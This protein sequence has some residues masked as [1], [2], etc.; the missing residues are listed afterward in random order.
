MSPDLRGPKNLHVVF[1]KDLKISLNCTLTDVYPHIWALVEYKKYK[2][3]TLLWNNLERLW[4]MNINVDIIVIQRIL[5]R[6]TGVYMRPHENLYP[7]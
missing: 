4:Y 2:C 6:L 7:I 3:V 5:A 1:D